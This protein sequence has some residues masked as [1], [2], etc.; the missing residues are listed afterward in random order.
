M[1]TELLMHIFGWTDIWYAHPG[2]FRLALL[3]GRWHVGIWHPQFDLLSVKRCNTEEE[4]EKYL[5]PGSRLIFG[6]LFKA[7]LKYYH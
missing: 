3:S 2:T 4:C 1:I 6:A 5:S 7:I